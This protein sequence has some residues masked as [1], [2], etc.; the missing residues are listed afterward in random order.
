[1]A[2]AVGF[3]PTIQCLTAVDPGTSPCGQARQ[4]RLAWPAKSCSRAGDILPS[5]HQ[6]DTTLRR[7]WLGALVVLLS[8]AA[9]GS[10]GS[11]VVPGGGG[12]GVSIPTPTASPGGGGGGE[13]AGV[14]TGQ[15]VF[16][17]GGT[18][19][20][21]TGATCSFSSTY[22]TAVHAG[23]QQPG[24]GRPDGISISIP[25]DN[26]LH[27]VISGSVGGKAFALGPDARGS[28]SGRSGSWSGTDILGSNSH[29]SGTFNCP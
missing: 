2:P 19:V 10:T 18:Q 27:A 3:E 5:P 1:M 26:S 28:V 22:G 25:P 12:G 17:A 11:T 13:S 9:C 7:L 4:P 15:V 23:D 14:G 8:V 16:S 29:F 6:E 21:L 20:T 24:D